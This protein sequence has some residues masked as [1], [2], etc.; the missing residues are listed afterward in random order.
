MTMPEKAF[1]FGKA[2]DVSD[3]NDRSDVS[4]ILSYMAKGSERLERMGDGL[5]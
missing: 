4:D 1:P 3:F 2:S 5:P